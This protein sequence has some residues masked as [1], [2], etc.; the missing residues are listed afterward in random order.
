MAV[1]VRHVDVQE[2]TVTVRIQVAKL[3]MRSTDSVRAQLIAGW[4][5]RKT[6]Y[7]LV[8]TAC[9]TADAIAIAQTVRRRNVSM[10]SIERSKFLFPTRLASIRRCVEIATAM[11][12]LLVGLKFGVSINFTV[13]LILAI[14]SG[15][16]VM[17]SP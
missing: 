14:V 9:V 1:A 7:V 3:V 4:I 11:V 6:Q 8:A 5:C 13:S 16:M 15:I 17:D 12:L 2:I 10:S